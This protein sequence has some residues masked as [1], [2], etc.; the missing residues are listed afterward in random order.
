MLIIASAVP[1]ALINPDHE[2][3]LVAI[4]FVAVALYFVAIGIFFTYRYSVLTAGERKI[5]H[6]NA[7][8]RAEWA[9]LLVFWKRLWYCS[10]C[11]LVYVLGY[12]ETAPPEQWRPL[13]DSVQPIF[14]GKEAIDADDPLLTDGGLSDPGRRARLSVIV[15]LGALITL[16]LISG[17]ERRN[18][19]RGAPL[20]DQDL[21]IDLAD[22]EERGAAPEPRLLPGLQA[23]PDPGIEQPMRLLEAR[24]GDAVE[25]RRGVLPGQMD[26]KINP[27]VPIGPNAHRAGILAQ[28]AP[29]NVDHP[30]M[31][32]D[33]AV[34]IPEPISVGDR[35]ELQP[36]MLRNRMV[37][38]VAKSEITS[39]RI[40]TGAISGAQLDRAFQLR[41]V[42]I[43]S[44]GQVSVTVEEIGERSARVRG[45]DGYGGWVPSS[46]LSK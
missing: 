8:E 29:A 42:A 18:P 38:W 32:P 22:A 6:R 30:G 17:T 23:A 28:Q 41:N 2:A 43:Y 36:V 11:D 7:W 3:Y 33:L 39:D 9:D 46:R 10:R 40:D 14:P 24:P 34:E 16:M 19:S 20:V 25:Q 12:Q 45:L 13:R 37:N 15:A 21:T 26:G 5:E 4:Q 35:V 1:F 44:T 27:A 31:N